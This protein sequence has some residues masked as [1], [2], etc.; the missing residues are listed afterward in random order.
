MGS[1]REDARSAPSVPGSKTEKLK[2][3]QSK[4][5]DASTNS[6]GEKSST[7]TS[8]AP[9]LGSVLQISDRIHME[10]DQSAAALPGPENVKE[11]SKPGSSP[12]TRDSAL[13]IRGRT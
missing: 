10:H 3:A 1:D 13:K 8:S 6:N 2:N 12:S 7:S 5:A 4:A 11:K 9:A